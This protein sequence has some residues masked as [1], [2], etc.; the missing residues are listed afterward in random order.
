MSKTVPFQTSQ[1]CIRMQFSYMLP[2]DRALS[3]ATIPYQSG[4]GSNNNEGGP[5]FPKA[6]ASLEL[7]HQ[8]F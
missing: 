6:Q 3:G 1:F 2:I 5:A 8:I 7:H 4:P